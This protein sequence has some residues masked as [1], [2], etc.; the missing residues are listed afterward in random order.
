MSQRACTGWQR[1]AH[2][3]VVNVHLLHA[4]ED[5]VSDAAPLHVDELRVEERLGSHKAL[6]AQLDDAPIW[7]RVALHQVCRLARQGKV[8]LRV[9]G[10]VAQ[11][12][13]DLAHGVHVRA[14]VKGVPAALQQLNQV[15]GDV[16][17]SHVEALGEMREGVA[18]LH[19]RRE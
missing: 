6:R 1:K 11:R 8:S 19:R 5:D 12:L 10:G 14:A 18:V 9:V 16:A 17:P 15:R 4:L 3:A 7:Q 2:H 13:L